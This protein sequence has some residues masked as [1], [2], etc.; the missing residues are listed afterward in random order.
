MS[1]LQA[2]GQALDQCA[3]K[4]VKVVVVG[5]PANTNAYICHKYAPSIPAQ[6]FTCLTR[7]DQSRAQAQVRGGGLNGRNIHIYMWGVH[8]QDFCHI[9]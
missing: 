2:Q 9:K 1:A 5:N 4:S 7:L 3:K 8:L 6:N